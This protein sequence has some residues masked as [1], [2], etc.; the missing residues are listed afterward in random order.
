MLKHL[1]IKN[2]NVESPHSRTISRMKQCGIMNYHNLGKNN[3]TLWYYYLQ[4]YITIDK[5]QLFWTLSVL[6]LNVHVLQGRRD[7]LNKE[8]SKDGN[9][10]LFF[11]Y[12]F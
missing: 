1:N 10:C 9:L 4:G 12:T 8:K 6:E 11:Q 2:N 3:L 5:F 7:F